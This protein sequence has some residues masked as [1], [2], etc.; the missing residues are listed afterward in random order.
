MAARMRTFAA[1][2]REMFSRRREDQE[3]SDEIREHL[4]MLTE[5]NVR[6]GMP[7]AEARRKAKIRFGGTTQLREM[8][9]ELTGIPFLETLLQD[10]RYALRMLRKS[11]GF[12]SVAVLTIALGIGATTAIFS[13]VDATLLR[14]LPYPHAEQLVS[15]RDDLVGLGAQDVGVSVPEWQDFEHSG[16]FEHVS[17]AW[18]DENDLTGASRPA[19]VRIL[20][21]APNYFALLGVK[22][23]LGRI[24]DPNDHRPGMSETVISDGLWRGAFGSDPHILDKSIRLDTDLYRVVGVMPAS[25]DHPGRTAEE[26]NVEAWVATNFYGMP[27][28]DH[29]ARNRRYMPTQIARIKTGLT[30][31]QAQSRVDALVASLQKQYPADYPAQSAWAVRLLP[32][33]ERITGNV[34]HS[35]LLLLGAVGLV[36]LIACV[37]IANLLLARGNA[38]GKEMAIRQALGG[39]RTRLIGQLLTESVLLSLLGGTV[40]L[41]ILLVAKGFLTHLIPQNLPRLNDISI[42]WDVLLF[43]LIAT[44]VAGVAFG[45]APALHTGR[46]DVTRAL[47]QEARGSTGSHGQ[48]RTRRTLAVTEFAVSLVLMIAASLLLHSFWNLLNVRLGFNP[49]NVMSVRTRLPQ[50]NDPKADIYGTPAQETVFLR[51]VLRRVKTL[52]G[53]EVAAVGDT[54]S[55]P[56]DASQHELK[57]I[58]EGPFFAIFEGRETQIDHAPAVERSSVTPDYFQVMGIPLLRGRF[59][60]ESDINS[61]PAVAVINEDFAHTY[62]PNENAVGKR[63]RQAGARSPWITVVGIVANAR[64]ESLATAAT[65]EVY[66]SLYQMPVNRLAIFLRGHLNTA[67]I[68]EQVRREVQAVDP[69]LPLFDAQ[70]LNE[71]LSASL[72]ERRFPMELIALFG[73]TALLL[74]GLGIYG[75]ISYAVTERT[76][77]IGIRLALGAQRRNILR[78]VLAQGL[79]LAIAGALVGSV[80]ALIVSRLMSGLLYGVKPTDS[81]TFVA[82]SILLILVALAACYIPARRAMKVDPMV[83]LRYE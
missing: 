36:L 48:T 56:L 44:L 21:V 50:P 72:A 12:T 57:L 17:P 52:P 32:L 9:R 51:E 7:P 69:R 39:S 41:T 38:R 5:E 14:P 63:F 68:P 26:R 71:T 4:D 76:H 3:F 78:M 61:S 10:V 27:M 20:I 19:R 79:Q 53:V 11:P 30:L 24:F 82:M 70:T 29:P 59:F 34:R 42:S 66:L 15:L 40:G 81:M 83:A 64:T 65:P 46:L 33:K 37:N 67:K 31:E 18:F 73:L 54:A 43:A 75:V 22:P 8:H 13:V 80:G 1:R 77:E 23:E 49:Q 45:L 16:I 25:F 58:S 6:R 47:K 55:I 62:W 35:L 28:P 74:A 2:I 60:Q